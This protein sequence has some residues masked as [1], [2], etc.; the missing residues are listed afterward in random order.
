MAYTQN[1]PSNCAAY[2]NGEWIGANNGTAHDIP[3]I[4]HALIVQL[5]DDATYEVHPVNLS[6]AL[7]DSV[8]ALCA[9]ARW[10]AYA[11]NHAFGTTWDATEGGGHFLD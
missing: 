2:A 7:W 10:F 3:T 5:K 1:T 9:Y 8:K 6:G 4:D 11:R